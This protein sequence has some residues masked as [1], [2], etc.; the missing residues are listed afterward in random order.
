MLTLK[1]LKFTAKVIFFS[2]IDTN[3]APDNSLPFENNIEN[4]HGN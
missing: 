3:L 4:N 2:L 1:T